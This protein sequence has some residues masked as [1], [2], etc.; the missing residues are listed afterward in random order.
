MKNAFTPRGIPMLMNLD[1]E[2]PGVIYEEQIG[3]LQEINL[4]LENDQS[5][6]M[7][8]ERIKKKFML[9]TLSPHFGWGQ[10]DDTAFLGHQQLG[11]ESQGSI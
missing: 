8:R 10:F 4:E 5:Y 7:A 11:S 1:L 6:K 9:G 2:T 3:P